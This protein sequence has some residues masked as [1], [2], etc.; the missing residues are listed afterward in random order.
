MLGHPPDA[1]IGRAERPVVR[2]TGAAALIAAAVFHLMLV[3]G[4]AVPVLYSLFAASAAGTLLGAALLVASAPRLGW[5]IGGG[6]AFLTFLGYV[7]TR[8]IGLPGILTSVGN[9]FYPLGVPSLVVEGIAF[10]LAGWALSDRHG[11]T[12]GRVLAELRSTAP[13][14]LSPPNRRQRSRR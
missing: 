10:L 3:P 1:Q 5:L 4:F 8:T 9:W 2:L 11:L 6:T 13:A 7:L 14:A 12:T